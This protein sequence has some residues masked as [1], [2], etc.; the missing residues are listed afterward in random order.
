MARQAESEDELEVVPAYHWKG[1]VKPLETPFPTTTAG[2]EFGLG[3]RVQGFG[4]W[5][6]GL[7]G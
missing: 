6:I 1:R 5:G 4:F 7:C 3:F 2:D